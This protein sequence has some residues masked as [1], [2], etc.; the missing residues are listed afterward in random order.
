[1]TKLSLVIPCFN[2]TATLEHAVASI[3]RQ[4]PPMPFDV[5][6]I[7]DGSTDATYAVMQGLAQ[8]HRNIR[9]LRHTTN[10]GG[11]A[12][13]NTAIRQTNGDLI[14]CLDSDDMLGP[15]F[16]DKMTG[17]W[18]RHQCDG[19]GMSTSIKFRG[20][21]TEDVAYVSEFERPGQ[22][23]RFES[24]LDGDRCSLGV[25]FLMRRSAFEKLGGYPTEHG[26]DTQG[27]AFR[28]L[29]NGLRAY[30]CPDSVYYH[31]VASPRSYY[32]REQAAGRLNW[33]W[34][35]VFDEFL[36]VFGRAAQEVILQHPLFDVPDEPHPDDLLTQVKGLRRIYASQYRRLVRGGPAQ[37]ARR[38]R[39][40]NNGTQ[41]YWVGN[42]HRMHGAPATALVHYSRALALGFKSRSI[43][44]R[45]LQAELT[46]SGR[47]TPPQEVL[48][49]M[50]NHSRPFPVRNRPFAE[51][52]FH[53]MLSN[54]Y[55]R[56]P[57]LATKGLKDRLLGRKT[58]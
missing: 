2:C 40:K 6:M 16:L 26:F 30:T 48:E 23:V 7:D 22:L 34:F 10:Q 32:K 31:R 46:L 49:E 50:L 45:M 25:V 39:E 42:F 4:N 5:T 21:N 1:M 27:M 8:S 53:E 55:L 56:E 11:G 51:R 52:L 58:S 14:F 3:Y 19:I 43:F 9:L 38:F 24:F 17:F 12:A 57:A 37:A 13:R 36:Y 20:D 18:K 44:Y 35:N 15:G 41:Q 47:S 54:R 29:C 33:N 28:F